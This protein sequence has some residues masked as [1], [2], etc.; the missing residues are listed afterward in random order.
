MKF[1][2]VYSILRYCALFILLLPTY[3][4]PT[5]NF[6][7]LMEECNVDFCICRIK[8]ENINFGTDYHTDVKCPWDVHFSDGR[9]P[10]GKLR[11]IM[12]HDHTRKAL[13]TLIDDPIKTSSSEYWTS[14]TSDD[15]GESYFVIVNETYAYEKVISIEDVGVAVVHKVKGTYYYD[16][17]VSFSYNFHDV[18]ECPSSVDPPIGPSPAPSAAPSSYEPSSSGRNIRNTLLGLVLVAANSFIIS[19]F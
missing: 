7:E 13:C 1:Q 5:S 17:G 9:F 10:E 11:S 14:A 2:K 4:S 12:T 18:M 6:T 19:R 16:E 15:V 8:Y 3:V